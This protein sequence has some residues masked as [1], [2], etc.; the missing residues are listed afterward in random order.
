[1]NSL[2]QKLA[3]E[4]VYSPKYLAKLM[5]KFGAAARERE[6]QIQRVEERKIKCE[7]ET[8]DLF[9]SIDQRLKS[10]LKITQV[11]LKYLSV[12]NIN[13]SLFLSRL[14]SQRLKLRKVLMMLISQLSCQS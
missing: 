8:E 4:E 12:T 6:K 7:K 11:C 2:E 14:L 10:H 5:D 13:I 9:D 3:C 1:M